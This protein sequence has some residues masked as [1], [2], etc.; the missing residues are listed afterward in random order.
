MLESRTIATVGGGDLVLTDSPVD[1]VLSGWVQE[2]NGDLGSRHSFMLSQ[3][4][5]RELLEGLRSR[6]G[7]SAIR[8]FAGTLSLTWTRSLAIIWFYR[9][10]AR[11]ADFACRLYDG[12][13]DAAIEALA[14]ACEDGAERPC[15]V[16]PI[17]RAA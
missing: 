13:I 11:E 14:E 15:E 17:K 2:P 1:G 3:S 8:T 6:D 10:E 12:A 5:A 7:L 16:V 4:S 9:W